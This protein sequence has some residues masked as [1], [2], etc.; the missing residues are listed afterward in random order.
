MH[1]TVSIMFQVISRYDSKSKKSQERN[2]CSQMLGKLCNK[3]DLSW[4]EA[5]FNHYLFHWVWSA[6]GFAT[7]YQCVTWGSCPTLQWCSTTCATSPSSQP[8]LLSS[9]NP[10]GWRVWAGLWGPALSNVYKEIW[11]QA[12][13]HLNRPQGGTFSS[14]L[15]FLKQH[16]SRE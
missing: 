16:L 11:E 13:Q 1:L 5:I 10:P 14:I 15:N 12:P 8:K 7:K 6:S 2:F 3:A 4:H 9:A